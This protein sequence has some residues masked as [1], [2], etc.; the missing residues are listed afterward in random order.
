MVEQ[1]VHTSFPA[2]NVDPDED[3]VVNKV[4]SFILTTSYNF[5]FRFWY[6]HFRT[7]RKKDSIL[8]MYCQNCGAL[9]TSG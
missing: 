9:L 1:E 3:E 8:K 5:C 7:S 6:T 4:N 2:K